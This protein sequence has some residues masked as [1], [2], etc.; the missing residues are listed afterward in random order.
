MKIERKNA[1]NELEYL[2][3]SAM[4]RAMIWS[5]IALVGVPIGLKVTLP[6]L[7]IVSLMLQILVFHVVGLTLLLNYRLFR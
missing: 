6:I 3:T 1:I 2:H 5:Y 7:L 4:E